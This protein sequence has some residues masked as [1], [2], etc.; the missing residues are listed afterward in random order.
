[1][2]KDLSTIYRMM[3]CGYTVGTYKG[4]LAWFNDTGDHCYLSNF[5]GRELITRYYQ[6]DA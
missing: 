5:Y 2:S 3:L 4:A 1:M 6:G